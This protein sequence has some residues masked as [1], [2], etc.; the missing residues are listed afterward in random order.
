MAGPDVSQALAG[1]FEEVAELVQNAQGALL[2]VE[3]S[4]AE[5]DLDVPS[6]YTLYR[7]MHT[8]KGLSAMVEAKALVRLAHGLETVLQELH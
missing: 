5:G 7:A 3:S 4:V 8:I 1:Y 6:L 2:S